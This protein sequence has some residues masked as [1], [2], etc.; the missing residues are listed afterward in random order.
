MPSGDTNNKKGKFP[1]TVPLTEIKNPRPAWDS[2]NQGGVGR[3]RTADTRIF[4]TQSDSISI[5]IY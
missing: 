2:E 3:D 4:S 5:I 1:P